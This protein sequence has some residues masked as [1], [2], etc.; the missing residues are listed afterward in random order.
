MAQ[1]VHLALM[2][3]TALT[4]PMELTVPRVT[5]DRNPSSSKSRSATA[6][7]GHQAPLD[8][9]APKDP[10][11]HQ[12]KTE[13]AV[14]EPSKDHQAPWDLQGP[15]ASLEP[16]ETREP[17]VLQASSFLEPDPL[18]H[19]ALPEPRDHKDQLDPMETRAKTEAMAWLGNPEN[20]ERPVHQAKTESQVL[21]GKTDRL[22][23]WVPA[24][25]AHLL[26]R[27]RDTKKTFEWLT[28]LDTV[29]NRL[30]TTNAHFLR[31]DPVFDWVYVC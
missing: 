27:P 23:D 20:L 15:Q 22:E 4:V 13:P 19:Q 12:A 9:K 10:M 16:L 18:A 7:P 30:W 14:P 6:L 17:P 1:L 28:G 2:E 25:T 24:P 5:M 31:Q 21:Q 26:V 29:W 11:E 8:L 3:P